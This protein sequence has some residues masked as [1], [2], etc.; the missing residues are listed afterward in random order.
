MNYRI[1]RHPETGEY[2]FEGPSD[3]DSQE[4]RIS[5]KTMCEL[6]GHYEQTQVSV[7]VLKKIYHIESEG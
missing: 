3:G 6:I 5:F 7:Y 4:E 2:A 1:I